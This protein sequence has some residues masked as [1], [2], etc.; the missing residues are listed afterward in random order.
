MAEFHVLFVCL[1]NICR[2][3]MAEGL[4]REKLKDENLDWAIG[5]RGVDDYHEGE[6]PDPRAQAIMKE[7]GFDIS[8]IR[9]EQFQADEFQWADKVLAMDTSNYQVLFDLAPDDEAR[10][11]LGLMHSYHYPNERQSVPDPYRDDEGFERVCEMMDKAVD[12]F[13]EEHRK[14]AP[15]AE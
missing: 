10:E 14:T 2:S 11:K 9:S 1:G 3:P 8:D 6:S 5:S 12:A 7:K 15:A 13:I 4:M